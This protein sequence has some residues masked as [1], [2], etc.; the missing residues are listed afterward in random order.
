MTMVS[1]VGIEMEIVDGTHAE[2]AMEVSRMSG[3][4]RALSECEVIH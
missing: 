3:D 2:K 4:A 1:C